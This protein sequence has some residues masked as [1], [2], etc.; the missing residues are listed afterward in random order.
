MATS[1]II[2]GD[3]LEL[4]PSIKASHE[5][6]VIVTDPPFNVGYHYNSYKDS[7][8]SREY[9]DML[10]RIF[11][12]V[13]F[14]VIHYPEQIYKI[15][16]QMNEAPEKVVSWVYNSNTPKQHRDIAFFG[17]KPD[18]TKYGQ[19]YKNP[20]DKRIAQRIA[21]G[22]TAKLYDWWEINQ[23]K[24]VSK[25]KTAHPCQMPL[26]VMRRIVGILPADYT[27][28]DP[29]MGSGTTALACKELGRNFIGIEM[30]E[31]YAAIAQSRL[32]NYQQPVD[33]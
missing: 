9:Y 32:D 15:A 3:C 27:I 28:V 5:K 26:E 8:E 6:L 14:V 7:M 13:P 23:V 16:F 12:D 25:E 10:G 1:E 33:N 20:K 24:N 19:P 2:V 21:E 22:K 30:D 29:F 31:T 17:I 4:L 11:H 18:F